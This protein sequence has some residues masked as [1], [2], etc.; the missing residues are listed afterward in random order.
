MLS[1]SGV[2]VDNLADLTVSSAPNLIYSFHFY[3]PHFF[4][5]QGVLG[6]WPPAQSVVYPGV[7]RD[8]PF[9][10]EM[11]YDKSVLEQRLLLAVNFRNTHNVRVMCGEFGTQN[12]R[13][14]GFP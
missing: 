11:F 14:D 10:P 1:R 3:E 12:Q 9:R 6:D 8:G 4:T 2:N 13:A 5:G 7:T